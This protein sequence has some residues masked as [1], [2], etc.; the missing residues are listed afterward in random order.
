MPEHSTKTLRAERADEQR[1]RRCDCDHGSQPKAS[2]LLV[3]GSIVSSGIGEVR[4][5]V[6][7]PPSPWVAAKIVGRAVAQPVIARAATRI[8][9]VAKRRAKVDHSSVR[10]MLA[11]PFSSWGSNLSCGSFI[12]GY[13]GESPMDCDAA[14]PCRMGGP[15]R[16]RATRRLHHRRAAPCAQRRW[17]A[18]TCVPLA[19]GGAARRGRC[20]ASWVSRPECHEHFE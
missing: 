8:A 19:G 7:P 18:G 4:G 12:C 2:H 15:T 5:V 9:R 1:A 6:R 3:A 16:A 13:T 14:G 20:S 11:T 17:T 10:F